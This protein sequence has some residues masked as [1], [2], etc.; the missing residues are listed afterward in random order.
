MSVLVV[1]VKPGSKKGPL[2]Q[3]ALDGSLLVYVREPAVD[4][5]ANQAVTQLLADY[6]NV[7][8]SHVQMVGG[9]TSRTKRFKILNH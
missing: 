1:R 9:R 6:L 7:P 4:G 2:V 5:K 8:K 3:P